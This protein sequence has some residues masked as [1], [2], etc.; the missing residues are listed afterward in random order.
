MRG[1]DKGTAAM[2]LLIVQKSGLRVRAALRAAGRP[3][4]R[5]ECPC[6]GI[7][8]ARYTHA[9]NC[10]PAARCRDHRHMALHLSVVVALAVAAVAPRAVFWIRSGPAHDAAACRFGGHAQTVATMR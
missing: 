2:R 8:Y 4:K 3:G 1:V 7:S 6:A 5:D 9:L 10:P